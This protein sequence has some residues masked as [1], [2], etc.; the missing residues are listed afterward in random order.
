MTSY[1]A[2]KKQIEDLEKKAQKAREAEV[3]DVVARMREAIKVYGITAKDL[4]LTA[5]TRMP[6]AVKKATRAGAGIPKY[7][8]PK[9]GKTWTGHGKP[10]MWIAGKK[11]RTAFL[12]DKTQAASAASEA[13]APKAA[14]PARAAKAVKAAKPTKAAAKPAKAVKVVKAAA[15]PAAKRGPKKAAEGSSAPAPSAASEPVAA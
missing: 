2:L 14:K 9:S 12:I 8:D 1:A 5:A 7:R 10:P 6:R 13:P 11:D 4:G 3:A 15:K